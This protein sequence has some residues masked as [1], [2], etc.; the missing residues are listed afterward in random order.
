MDLQ[1]KSL[2]GPASAEV[3]F[4]EKSALTREDRTMAV[5]A[6]DVV[7]VMLA[8]RELGRRPASWC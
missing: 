6:S 5:R 4:E 8:N 7:D 2:L 3:R 1:L